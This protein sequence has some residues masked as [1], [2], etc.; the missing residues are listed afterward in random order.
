M[1]IYGVDYSSRGAVPSPG[2]LKADGYGFVMRYLSY[3][4]GKNITADEL[5]ALHAAGISVG[6]VWESTGQTPLGGAAAGASDGAEAGRQLRALG[7]PASIFVFWAFDTDDRGHPGCLPTLKAYGDAFARACGHFSFPYGSNRVIDYFGGGWQTQAWSDGQGSVVSPHAFL[8]QEA[9]GAPIANTDR[10]Q[11]FNARALYPPNYQAPPVDAVEVD[12]LVAVLPDITATD[13]THPASLALW[14]TL[15]RLN[16]PQVDV[17]TDAA[18]AKSTE[19]FRT[20][21]KVTGD[22]PGRIGPNMWAAGLKAAS[23]GGK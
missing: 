21:Y 18:T 20:G 5:A 22:A 11:L 23:K 15:L 8:L 17:S 14:K 9:S 3:E 13:H 16:N 10:D 1:T 2:A 12:P 6:F 4:P 19:Q 7:V